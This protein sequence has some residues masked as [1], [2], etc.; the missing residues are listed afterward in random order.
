MKIKI[1]THFP[2]DDPE[3]CADYYDIEIFDDA[4]NQ[5]AYFG[6]DYHDSGYDKVE[7]FIEGIEWAIGKKIKIKRIDIAD[8]ED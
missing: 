6:D 3:F 7:G 2:K 1:V 8:R 4:D 5:I